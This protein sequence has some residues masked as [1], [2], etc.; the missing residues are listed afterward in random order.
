MSRIKRKKE[1]KQRI[2]EEGEKRLIRRS[3]YAA[4][5]IAEAKENGEAIEKRP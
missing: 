3:K 5:K 2:K 4:K 1:R